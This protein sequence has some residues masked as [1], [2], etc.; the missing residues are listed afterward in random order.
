MTE[1]VLATSS[2]RSRM[3]KCSPSLCGHQWSELSGA[4][5][6]LR[7]LKREPPWEGPLRSHLGRPSPAAAPNDLSQTKAS[8]SQAE[9]PTHQQFRFQ[10]LET[11]HVIVQDWGQAWGTHIKH[12]WPRAA[13]KHPG[14]KPIF[15]LALCILTNSSL[16]ETKITRHKAI[17]L[18]RWAEKGQRGKNNQNFKYT[19]L[20]SSNSTSRD[21]Q[22]HSHMYTKID[23]IK[24]SLLHCL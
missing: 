23:T 24:C 18:E 5:A 15:A 19:D 22:T 7:I 14:P 21:L 11:P 6:A 10:S 12:P 3:S 17:R 16:Q 9:S 1:Y 20:W 13:T 4:P 8:L 2:C